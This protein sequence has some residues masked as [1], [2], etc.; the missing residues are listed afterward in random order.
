MNEGFGTYLQTLTQAP[1]DKKEALLVTEEHIHFIEEDSPAYVKH[2]ENGA[3]VLY[4]HPDRT[5]WPLWSNALRLLG[6]RS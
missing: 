1:E 6:I 3:L 5:L 4:A 2:L